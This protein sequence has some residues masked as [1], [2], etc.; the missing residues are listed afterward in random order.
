MY[1]KIQNS[2]MIKGDYRSISRK[3][4]QNSVDLIIIDPPWY[5]RKYSNVFQIEYQKMMSKLF[6]ELQKVLKK[7]GTICVFVNLRQGSFLQELLKHSQMNLKA[8]TSLKK[9]VIL[10]AYKNQSVFMKRNHK[11]I[12]GSLAH[13]TIGQFHW[14]AVAHLIESFTQPGDIVFDPFCGSGTT[15]IVANRKGRVGIG[16]VGSKILFDL[17]KKR[18]EH[19]LKV[20][21][22][23]K[24]TSLWISRKLTEVERQQVHCRALN[25]CEFCRSDTSTIVHHLVPLADLGLNH[26]DYLAAL[27]DRCH[28]LMHDNPDYNIELC[29]KLKKRMQNN[30]KAPSQQSQKTFDILDSLSSPS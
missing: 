10:L 20:T 19:D 24:E 15:P 27:C 11:K 25:N 3:I 6:I 4:P 30:W 12:I 21:P 18:L 17:A 7:N 26:H 1:K 9:K 8:A 2:M 23:N 16:L 28:R 14:K 22:M 13:M 29:K 5:P